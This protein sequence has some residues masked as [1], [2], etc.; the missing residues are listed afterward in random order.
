MVSIY[1]VKKEYDH[2]YSNKIYLISGLGVHIVRGTNLVQV[3]HTKTQ[4]QEDWVKQ[5]LKPEFYDQ[6]PFTD[7]PSAMQWLGGNHD[8]KHFGRQK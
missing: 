7:I 5:N 1:K 6:Y 3:F 4:T 8:I 2:L